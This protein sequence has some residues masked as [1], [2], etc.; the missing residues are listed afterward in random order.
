[1]Q[2][3]TMRRMTRI[4]LILGGIAVLILAAG[5]FF[6]QPWAINTWPW[7]DGRLSYIFIASIQ[8]A[9]AVAMIWIGL[10]G[11]RGSLPAGALNIF[12]MQIGMAGF[13]LLH[14]QRT[15]QPRLL[16]YAIGLG[17]VSLVALGSFIAMQRHPFPATQR[18]PR[19]VRI[20][21]G[22]FV[23]ALVLV[24]GA[25]VLQTGG[26]MPWPLKPESSVMFGWIFL[27]DA[28]YFLYAILY[29]YWSFARAQLW[30]FLAY[31]LVLIVPFVDHLQRVTPEL[32]PSLLI[33]LAV[34]LYSG[35]LAVVY[36]FLHKPTRIWSGKQIKMEQ[37]LE[38]GLH[39]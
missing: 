36:L 2:G 32:M 39:R 21:F 37:A 27:G 35:S 26:I 28:F 13:L 17:V 33:Y 18:M 11:D 25:L 10:S 9:I 15:S 12:V 19:F 6:Q 16:L 1:M 20:S 23:V 3:E 29:P 38:E 8:V 34:L 30:S 5:Y 14:S 24:G 4:F 22:I 31:D 7:P